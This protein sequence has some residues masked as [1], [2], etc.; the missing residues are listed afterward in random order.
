MHACDLMVL[1][2]NEWFHV[3]AAK[4]QCVASGGLTYSGTISVTRQHIDCQRWDSQHS[5]EHR[6]TDPSRFPDA[7][8]ADAANYCRKPDGKDLPWCYTVSADQLWDYCDME[9]IFWGMTG[10]QIYYFIGDTYSWS[11]ILLKTT[12][13]SFYIFF[14]SNL[15]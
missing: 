9:A 8:L 1:I 6:Y 15:S 12:A 2:C 5:H 11:F 4:R 13:H 10:E 7:T 3:I 14:H